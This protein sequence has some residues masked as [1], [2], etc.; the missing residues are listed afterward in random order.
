MR[1]EHR[2]DLE[3]DSPDWGHSAG[4]AARPDSAHLSASAGGHPGQAPHM[5]RTEGGSRP[6]LSLQGRLTQESGKSG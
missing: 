1:C 4:K 2:R 3:G 5:A 6:L